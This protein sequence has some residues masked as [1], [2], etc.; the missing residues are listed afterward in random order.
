MPARVDNFM[1][2]DAQRLEAH[3][4]YR[5]GDAKAI[6][7]V[8]TGVGC[9]IARAMTPAL[10]KELIGDELREVERIFLA[11]I[12]SRHPFVSEVLSHLTSY[13]GKRL[14]FWRARLLDIIF[15]AP[16]WESTRE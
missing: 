9:P 11:E 16:D 3:E 14:L 4:L 7:L 8:S 2:V 15:N 6:V 12:D 13:R 5:L 1:L 10:R